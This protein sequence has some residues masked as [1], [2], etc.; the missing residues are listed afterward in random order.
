MR[1]RL[2]ALVTTLCAVLCAAGCG[3][4][5]ARPAP[6]Q[7]AKA[8]PVWVDPVCPGDGAL[9]GRG[10]IP[11]DFVA[12]SVLRC[13]QV[14]QQA[15]D[16]KATRITERADTPAEDLIA[17]LRR[18]SDPQKYKNCPAIAV[19]APYVMLVGADGRG[20]VPTLPSD[21]CGIPRLEVLHLLDKL[22]Y[23]VVSETPVPPR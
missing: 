1:T 19:E 8:E 2:L 6:D 15:H 12:V 7:A 13:R 20:L 23:R 21:G 3:N 4:A 18:P 5:A 17:A 22:P 10:G 14:V 11:E 9:P 16:G